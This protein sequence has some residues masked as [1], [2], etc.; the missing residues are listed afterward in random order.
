MIIIVVI[1]FLVG[2][3][4]SLMMFNISL[5]ILMSKRSKKKGEL[6]EALVVEVKEK[7]IYGRSGYITMFHAMAEI[8]GHAVNKVLMEEKP[9]VGS[10]ITV[11]QNHLGKFIIYKEYSM[12]AAVVFLMLGIFVLVMLGIPLY[13]IIPYEMTPN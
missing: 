8:D 6:R 3:F 11:F 4:L 13:S 2:L 7:V 9:E 1:L 12:I 5:T 10:F